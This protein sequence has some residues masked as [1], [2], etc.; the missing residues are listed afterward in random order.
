MGGVRVCRPSFFLHF[1]LEYFIFTHWLYLK[2]KKKKSAGAHA[3][4]NFI[5]RKKKEGWTVVL[6]ITVS[7]REGQKLSCPFCLLQSSLSL[8][9]PPVLSLSPFF[10]ISLSRS[11]QQSAL[12]HLHFII[13]LLVYLPLIIIADLIGEC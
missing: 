7:P 4:S 3:L 2:K 6:E 11:L 13:H 10:S 12:S 5:K 9:K 8:C 1:P